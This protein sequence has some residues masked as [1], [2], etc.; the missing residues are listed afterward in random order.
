MLFSKVLNKDLVTGVSCY[1]KLNVNG[2]IA[3]KMFYFY[4]L[5]VAVPSNRLD[6]KAAYSAMYRR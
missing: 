4:T 2:F 3:D 6:I 5:V 1:V